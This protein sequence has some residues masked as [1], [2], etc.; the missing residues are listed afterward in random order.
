R[1]RTSL[2]TW[3]TGPRTTAMPYSASSTVTCHRKKVLHE[4]LFRES[5]SCRSV[6]HRICP[7]WAVPRPGRSRAV[8]LAHTET[9]L[10]DPLRCSRAEACRRMSDHRPPLLHGQSDVEIDLVS[11]RLRLR[12]RTAAKR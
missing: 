3:R 11:A 7:G 4:A 6:G 8:S 10:P 12:Q 9:V 5:P 1:S 2:L